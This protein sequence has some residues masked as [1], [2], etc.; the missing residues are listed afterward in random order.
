MNHARRVHVKVFDSRRGESLDL[1]PDP[2]GAELP[3]SR[4]GMT[5]L[6]AENLDWAHVGADL[7]PLIPESD[8]RFVVFRPWAPDIKRKIDILAQVWQYG[9]VVDLAPVQVAFTHR[10]AV[11]MA[12]LL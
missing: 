12:D 11:S 7:D 9:A 4:L 8:T 10:P 3:S 6:R 2:K 5:V 1:R